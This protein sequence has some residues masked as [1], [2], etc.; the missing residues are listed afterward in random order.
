MIWL[1]KSFSR[2]LE[3]PWTSVAD[4][5]RVKGEEFRNPEGANRRTLR[6]EVG[7]KGYFLK[8]HW[9]VGWKEILKN[10]LSVRLPVIGAS[11]EW[12]A[13]RRLEEL[14]V[15]TMHL[16]AYGSDGWNPAA[17]RSFVV[18]RELENTVSL[19]DY[20]AD[21]TA[22]PPVFAEK[23]YLIERVAEMTRQLHHNG[24]NHRDLYICHFLL[25]QPW[26]G[27]AEGLHLYLIDLHRVQLRN[28]VPRRWVVKDVGSLYFSAMEAGLT[29]RDLYRFLRTYHA[30]SLRQIFTREKRFL[31]STA[32]RAMALKNK[33]IPDE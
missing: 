9:G 22:K 18:T 25:Q 15:E 27:T 32:D 24:V 14:G 29:R 33:G 6:F 16:E 12:R 10:L 26:D 4:A 7:G 5:F 17:Q 3:H 19:E 31:Q 28:R 21:W 8:L 20:C 1:S 2:S 23:R 30:K 11:N 13:I